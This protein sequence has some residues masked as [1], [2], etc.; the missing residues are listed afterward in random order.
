MSLFYRNSHTALYSAFDVFPTFKGSS[1]HIR[2]FSQ[3]LFE[4]MGNLALFTLADQSLPVYES[5]FNNQLEIYRFKF[6]FDN[7]LE[8]VKAYGEVLQYAVISQ[9]YLKIA[10]FR[11]PW[12]GFPILKSKNS[13]CKTVY[14]VNAFYSIELVHLYASIHQDTLKKIYEIEQYCLE[15]ADAIIVVSEL[16]KQNV[17]NRGIPE[18][19]IHCIPNGYDIGLAEKAQ[20]CKINDF[21]ILYFGAIQPW[22]GLDILLRALPYI[23]NAQ[24]R[25]KIIISQRKKNLK[26]YY[27]LAD[28]LGI[29]DKIDWYYEMEQEELFSYIQNACAVIVPLI[30]CARNSEQGC[31]PL[32]IIESMGNGALVIASDLPSTRELIKNQETGILCR[33]NRP[34]E[35]ARSIDWALENPQKIMKIKKNAENFVKNN[36]TWDMQLSKLISVYQDILKIK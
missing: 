21:Y 35:L 30:D 20:K 17:L 33:S 2:Y 26:F 23:Q 16:L 8:R 10:H 32:K 14:E 25:L 7:Y 15:N 3:K 6:L 34:I 4:F 19:K 11:D 13:E 12:S 18:N 9:P 28:K 36:Y 1:T 5:D 24:L 27:K 31:C 22:Q 29:S